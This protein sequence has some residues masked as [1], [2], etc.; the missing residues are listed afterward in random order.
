[1]VL[2]DGAT[3]IP[4]I[5]LFISI[6]SAERGTSLI[7]TQAILEDIF[8]PN[9]AENVNADVDDVVNYIKAAK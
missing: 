9:I 1:M 6:V 4:N 2:D 5:D 7:G 3:N 8:N